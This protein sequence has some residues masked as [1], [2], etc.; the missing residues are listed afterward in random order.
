MPK[1]FIKIPDYKTLCI[2]NKRFYDDKALKISFENFSML[3]TLEKYKY[4]S[5]IEIK[6]EILKPFLFFF[7]IK[8]YQYKPIG[9][10][11]EKDGKM[12]SEIQKPFKFLQNHVDSLIIDINKHLDKENCEWIEKKKKRQIETEVLAE[13]LDKVY[14]D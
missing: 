11:I 8:K 13:K 6:K 12:V 1:T 10:F 14:N 9:T 3:T 7:K 2:K 5:S 4:F